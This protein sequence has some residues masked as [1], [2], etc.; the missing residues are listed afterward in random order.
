MRANKLLLISALLIA[1][2]FAS[3][4]VVASVEITDPALRVLQEHSFND[5]KA[6]GQTVAAYPFAFPFYLSRKLDIDEKAQKR[7]DQHSIRFE[8]Y[9]GA[10]VIAISGNYYGAYAADK[11]NEEQR[12]RQTFLDVVVPILKSVVPTFQTNTA[13]QGYA[14]E[15]SHHVINKTMGM[16]I[17]RPEN[18]MVYV[19]QAAAMKLAAAQNN[20]ALQG[21]LLDAS[22]LLNAKQLSIWLTDEDQASGKEP[23]PTTPVTIRNSTAPA[24][25]TVAQNVAMASLHG[26][27]E[28]GYRSDRQPASAPTLPPTP[29]P[30][31]VAAI[32]APPMHDSS[33]QALAALQT[34]MQGVSNHILKELEPEAHFVTYAPPAF[35]PFHHQIYLELSMTTALAEPSE[36]SRYK[37]AALAFDE[38]V[39]PLIR[40]VLTYFSSDQN[41]DG[42]SFSTTVHPRTKPGAPAPKALSVEF[43]FPLE[44]LRRYASY[45]C[46]G[47]QLINEG[48]VLING[49][50]AGLDLELAQ[51][52]GRP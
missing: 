38:H 12:A 9:E 17:E 20:L 49:E 23:I 6:V 35:V 5:L 15:V 43:F 11:F 42:V 16:P 14:V 10:T 52:T 3:A 30:A 1:A 37:L 48:I 24:V 32:P 4:Q 33:P 51:G 36:T 46:T 7:A 31:P 28:T 8:H 13:V 34:A 22:V 19:P 18:L 50:R 44:A 39:S 41:F 47:Q 27:G 21:A 29:L 2:K 45:D 40:R 26:A 25:T